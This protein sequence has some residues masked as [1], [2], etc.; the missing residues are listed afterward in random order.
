[1]EEKDVRGVKERLLKKNKKIPAEKQVFLFAGLPSC[2]QL[3]LIDQ[4]PLT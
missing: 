4:R 3:K 1:M 2:V